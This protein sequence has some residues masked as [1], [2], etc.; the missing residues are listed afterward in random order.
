MNRIFY[1]ADIHLGHPKVANL[2]GF[3]D[4]Y[5]HDIAIGLN[6]RDVVGP[7]DTVWV[8]GDLCGTDKQTEYALETIAT[9]PG[10]KHLVTGNHDA[11]WPARSRA[12]RWQR[13]YLEVFE[14][15]QPF[16]VKKING[17]RCPM[18]H[19][20]FSGDHTEIARFDEW[21]LKDTGVP[22]IHGHT[23]SQVKTSQS[24]MGT[25]QIHVGL[26]AWGLKPA[27]ES[28]VIKLLNGAK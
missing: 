19:F 7:D 3:E 28:E 13:R 2:R 27:P 12:H 22:I 20:P 6:W 9:F 18:S 25:L 14:S 8:L 24:S 16:T 5:D 26:D 4:M 23:H 17:I 15:V 1:S 21:R 11:A 10:V